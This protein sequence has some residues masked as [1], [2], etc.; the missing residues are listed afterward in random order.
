MTNDNPVARTLSE[1]SD[2]EEV[3]WTH[4][5]E[6]I[7]MLFLSVAQIEIALRESE[8]SVDQLAK[9][10]TS[11]LGRE[12]QIAQSVDQLLREGSD[13]GICQAIKDNTE[14]TADNMRTAVVAFQ[15][16]DKLTQRLSHVGT[17]IEDLSELLG[18]ESRIGKIAEWRSLQ[19]GLKSRY[20]MS[21][22]CEL[23]NAV[24]EGGD[25]RAAV[26]RY[27]ETHSQDLL[28]DIEL[29]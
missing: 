12:T 28:D 8:D 10:F 13:Q 7:R 3:S 2:A 6:T 25:V 15:F 9:T 14:Q 11:M 22:E 21:E 20:S 26:R 23:F 1:Q 4:V 27:N 29:F 5:H 18:D 19:D 24:M 16:Y 17:S